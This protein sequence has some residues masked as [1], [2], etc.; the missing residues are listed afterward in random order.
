M[1]CSQHFALSTCQTLLSAD[2]VPLPSRNAAFSRRF[3][4][5]PYTTKQKKRLAAVLE[6]FEVSMMMM[7]ISCFALSPF[8]NKRGIFPDVAT[9]EC[10]CMRAHIHIHFF[11]LFSA[12]IDHFLHLTRCWQSPAHDECEQEV[13]ANDI[14]I[15]VHSLNSKIK[16]QECG[17]GKVT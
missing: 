6:P 9:I 13:K 1:F 10:V 7:I 8:R 15:L 14:V 5:K 2:C 3:L 16:T 12:D 17:P 11:D 4:T